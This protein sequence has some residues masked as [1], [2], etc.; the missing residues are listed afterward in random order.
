MIRAIMAVDEEGGVSKLGTMP[1]PKNIEDMK[2]FKSNTINNMVVMGKIT[3]IDPNMPTPL[4]NRVNVLVTSKPPSLYPGADRYVSGDLIN[5]IKKIQI[6][7][8]KLIKWIIGGPN[9]INQL[10]DLID[11]FYLT[12]INGRFNCDKKLDVERIF[13]NMKLT[14]SKESEDHS[15][16]FEIWKR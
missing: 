15:C 10:F 4:K 9:I 3:W 11:E 1:W 16:V 13:K 12:R 7:Y 14:S 2:W 8:E 6:E 5:E